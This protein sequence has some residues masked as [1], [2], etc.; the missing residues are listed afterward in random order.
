MKTISAAANV[1]FNFAWQTILS[2]LTIAAYLLVAQCPPGPI[3]SRISLRRR[4]QGRDGQHDG[5][6]VD[7]KLTPA[8]APGRV[9][10]AVVI[11]KVN[12]GIELA[13]PSSIDFSRDFTLATW[14]NVGKL[15]RGDAGALQGRADLTAA[16]GQVLRPL[17]HRGNAGAWRRPG[18]VDHQLPRLERPRAER[19]RMA[20]HRGDL[21]RG[22]GSPLHAL[23]GRPGQD[24]R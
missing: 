13:N 23:C 11:E 8:F 22:G 15:L 5:S 7:P 17:R 10:N 21:S 1:R 16:P 3:L 4:P 12:A 6:S 14:V 2:R 9:G 18:R 19:R 24:S 20:S